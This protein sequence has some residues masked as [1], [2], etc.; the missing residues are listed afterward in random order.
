V[1]SRGTALP[2]RGDRLAQTRNLLDE[3]GLPPLEQVDR[4]EE[5][6]ARNERATIV[7]HKGQDST[8][9]L[10]AAGVESA[11]YA[12]RA[13]RC[14]DPVGS[15]PPYGL[16]IRRVD[17]N[18]NM[19]LKG[20]SG[21]FIADGNSS[22]IGTSHRSPRFMSRMRAAIRCKAAPRTQFERHLVYA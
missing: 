5:T 15:N 8:F 19:S 20:P 17:R 2:R 7:R 13:A 21:R 1:S 16:V 18:R 6:P 22:R 4:E 10:P 14:A 12:H 9:D 3:Q 11:D